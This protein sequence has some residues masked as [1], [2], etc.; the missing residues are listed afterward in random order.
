[1]SWRNTE[2]TRRWNVRLPIVQAPMAGGWTTPA[3]VAAVSEAGALGSI[4]GAMLGPDALREQIRAVR[5]FTA[6]PFAVNLFAPQPAPSDRGVTEWAALTGVS[7]PSAPV[8]RVEFADQLAV[9]LDERVPV[10]SFT[11]G[12]PPLGGVDCFTVGTATTVAEAVA[13]AAAGVD[14]VVAQGFEAGGHR[15]TFLTSAGSDEAP[16]AIG[17]MALVPQIV[18]AVT[19]PVIASGGIMDGRGI[20]AAARSVPPPFRS[21][22]LSCGHP[23]PRPAPTTAPRSTDRRPSPGCSPGGMRGPSGRRWW[24]G[25]GV[26]DCGRRT[27]RCPVVP[28]RVADAGRAGRTDGP[29]D[30][31]G[32]TC[33]RPGRRNH[34]CDPHAH[35]GVTQPSAAE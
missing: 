4:A 3:L 2:L 12:I 7:P 15:G 34:R 8:P 26:R 6:Q 30:A 31:G 14:A 25:V 28:D 20:A 21:G 23:R 9:V 24:I 19:I 16:D 29:H 22:R 13:L 11:F 33:P 5:A 32:R 18:D 17:T 1:M 35:S 10:L 27:T